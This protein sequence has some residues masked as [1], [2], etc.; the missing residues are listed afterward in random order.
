MDEDSSGALDAAEGRTYLAAMGCD[1]ADLEFTWEDLRRCADTDGD[2]RVS[3]LEFYKYLLYQLELDDDGNFSDTAH[4]KAIR[5]QIIRMGRAGRL[6]ATLF[7]CLD[8]DA[9]G[10]YCSL[11]LWQVQ[12]SQKSHT[13]LTFCHMWPRYISCRIPRAAGS[14][15][16]P[17]DERMPGR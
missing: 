12:K 13:A 5:I 16:V 3:K 10:E 6:G 8:M 9:S 15:R 17:D 1:P 2:G 7:D 11:C 14:S 4:E